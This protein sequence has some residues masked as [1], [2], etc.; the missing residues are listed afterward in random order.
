MYAMYSG[1][2]ALAAAFVWAQRS[3]CFSCRSLVCAANKAKKFIITK[4]GYGA[5]GKLSVAA[6]N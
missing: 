6:M 2:A 5:Y 4:Y 1:S 3:G